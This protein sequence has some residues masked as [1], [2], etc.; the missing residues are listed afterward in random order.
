MLEDYDVGNYSSGRVGNFVE[1]LNFRIRAGDKVLEDPLRLLEKIRLIFQKRVKIRSSIAVA[2]LLLI[3]LSMK[4]KK[5]SFFLS[6][7]M[8]L[9]I[10]QV[11]NKCL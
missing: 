11:K 10:H 6:L 9:L 7:L 3:L 1:S 8:K 2:R 5:V 4:S